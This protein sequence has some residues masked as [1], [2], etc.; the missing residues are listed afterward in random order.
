MLAFVREGGS[1]GGGGWGEGEECMWGGGKSVW[2]EEEVCGEGVKGEEC[3]E[4]I[5][6]FSPLQEAIKDLEEQIQRHKAKIDRHQKKI[7]SH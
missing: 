1:V 6:V 5:I 7:E 3:T 2:G 4:H